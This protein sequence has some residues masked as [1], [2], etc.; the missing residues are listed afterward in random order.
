MAISKI[1]SSVFVSKTARMDESESST[2]GHWEPNAD[3][4]VTANGLVIK[5]ELAGMRGEDLEL[6]IEGNRLRI[7]GERPD[8]CRE[9]NCDFLVMSISYGPFESILDLPPGYELSRAKAVYLN[10]FLR[11]DVPRSTTRRPAR[12]RLT[13]RSAA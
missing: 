3:V 2:P 10:G 6:S 8:G 12:N 4:Y 1:S 9:P 13:V 11:V 5:V 7:T